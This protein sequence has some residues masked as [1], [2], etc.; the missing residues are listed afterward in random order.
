MAAGPPLGTVSVHSGRTERKEATV[1]RLYAPEA[2]ARVRQQEIARDA[3][4]A[5]E[6]SRRI[7]RQ[8]R[9]KESPLQTSRRSR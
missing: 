3:E 6:Q 7:R 9:T 5:R 1:F 8:K 4:R 2:L